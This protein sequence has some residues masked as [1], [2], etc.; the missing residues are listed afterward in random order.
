MIYGWRAKM[1]HPLAC[2][3]LVNKYEI[4]LRIHRR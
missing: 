2:T 3:L 1:K 4:T